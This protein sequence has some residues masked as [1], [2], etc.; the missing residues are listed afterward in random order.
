MIVSVQKLGHSSFVIHARNHMLV[1]DQPELQGGTDAGMTPPELL[2]A[3]L[4]TCVAYYVAE[5]CAARHLDCEA[6]VTVRGEIMHNPGRIG[7]ID[8]DVT[9]PVNLSSER[10]N[11]LLRTATHCTI[12]NTLTCPPEIR[13]QVQTPGM[14]VAS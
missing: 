12:H 2:L 13:V 5:F 7:A 14:A 8:I 3:S 10:L 9:L 4:G 6:G 1:S 11:A